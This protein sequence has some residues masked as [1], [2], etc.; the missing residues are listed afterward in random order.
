MIGACARHPF[1]VAG[2]DRH[3]TRIML[4]VPRVFVKTGAEGVYVAAVAH[5]GI[6]SV[7]FICACVYVRAPR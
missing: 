7:S 2:T 6:G 1:M 5:A 4:A 3:C